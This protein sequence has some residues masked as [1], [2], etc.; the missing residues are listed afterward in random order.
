MDLLEQCSHGARQSED[1]SRCV[2]E[3]IGVAVFAK[4][5]ILVT[6]HGLYAP[7]ATVEAQDGFGGRSVKAG[8]QEG[9]FF[10]DLDDATRPDMVTPA[11]E[12]GNRTHR[13]PGRAHLLG[14]S[15]NRQQG[16]AAL[17]DAAMTEIGGLMSFTGGKRPARGR[18]FEFLQ[19]GPSG[20][21]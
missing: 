13:G 19:A 5:D 6:V 9:G 8:N 20:S 17:I 7:V 15:F 11:S 12:A 18:L 4:T 21:S 10:L 16:D 1:V 14:Q 2:P 3:A